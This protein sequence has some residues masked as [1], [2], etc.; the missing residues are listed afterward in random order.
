MKKNRLTNFN[1][2]R[3]VTFSIVGFLVLSLPQIPLASAGV[4]FDVQNSN[5]SNTAGNSK[6]PQLATVGTNV[7][8]VWED[9]TDIRF[10][11][12]ANNGASFATASAVDI[13]DNT[14]SANETP[15]PQIANSAG[16]DVYITWQDNE[17]IRFSASANNGASFA[18]ASAV[19]IGNTATETAAKPQIASSG[20]DVYIVWREGTDIRFSASANNGASFA[21]ASAVD[22]GDIN[23]GGTATARPSVQ[24]ASAGN[25]AYVIWVDAADI[26]FSASANNGAS[27]AVSAVDIGNTG[28]TSS[29]FTSNPQIAASGTNVFVIWEDGNTVKFRRSTDSGANFD[30]EISIGN[31]G[32]G[33]NSQPQ[34]AIGS[35]NNVFVVWQDGATGEIKYRQ[36]TDNGANFVAEQNLSN[37]STSS[38]LPQITASG[39]N[40]F[41]IWR[42]ATADTDDF[43][44]KFRSSTDSG[45]TFGS[46]V[47]LDSN[48]LFDDAP[49]VA[50]V[51]TRVYAV[52]EEKTGSAGTDGEIRFSAATATP[53]SVTFDAAQYRLSETA[54]V[55]IVDTDSNTDNASIQTISPTVTSTTDATGITLSLTETTASSGTFSGTMTFTTAVGGS[56][57]AGRILRVSTGDTITATFSSVSGTATIFPRTVEFHSTSYSLGD[58]AHVKVTDQNSNTDNAAIQ[59]IVVT[60]TSTTDTT[61]ISLTLT[62]T[63]ASSGIF[64]GVSPTFTNDLIFMRG[65]HLFP[66]P[67]SV[68]ITQIHTP[69]NT[70]PAA[71][72][73]T[74]VSVSST[75]DSTPPDVT[76][77]LT[78]NGANT[79]T[80]TGTLSLITG[81]S[82]GTSIQ[83]VA[84]D[85]L[86]ILDPTGTFATR[87][88][89]TP[90]TNPAK[91][92]LHVTVTDSSSDIVTATY[93]GSSASVPVI[94]SP[95]ESGGGGGGIVRP[96]L[97]LDVLAGLAGG[98]RDASPPS[99]TLT[100]KSI[101]DLKLDD[102]I[103][104]TLLEHDPFKPIPPLNDPTIE[105]P[106]SIS[107]NGYLL[108]AYA[109]T[110]VTNTIETGTPV[111]VNLAFREASSLEHV[112]LYTNLRGLEKEIPNSDTYIVYNK[113]KPVEVVDPHGIFSDVKVSIEKD[114]LKHRLK[115]DITF[116]KSMEK[117]D[118]ILRAW[119]QN[120][121]SID[122]KIFDA[123]Q[124]V[125][126]SETSTVSNEAEFAGTLTQEFRNESNNQNSV[127]LTPILEKWGGFSTESASDSE[128]LQEIGI[129]ASTIPSW[130]KENARWILKGD[131]SQQEFVDALRYLFE[132]GII[133]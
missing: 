100:T 80:F 35:G 3:L 116:A 18:T 125:E 69:A 39:T 112:A 4:V 110:I 10:S 119:D 121:N 131:V 117:S 111:E 48:A 16:S 15:N 127:N 81:P 27:F 107:D 31:A 79:A 124:V 65:T 67:G 33:V 75:T 28:G 133:N 17:D 129:E 132:K 68:T 72:D 105:Y 106:F 44:I 130:V 70:N 26:R 47:D 92:A 1:A 58:I 11:A 22:I 103:R 87:G 23:T 61:G 52:W 64:G 62:E 104:Q 122:T 42:E 32:L 30:S 20:N 38:T 86:T 57:S 36:S 76:I 120:K 54:T 108:P 41:V 46:A 5:L 53:I 98:G 115:Y 114:G 40:V 63:T 55:T 6:V 74:S 9:G 82:S 77:P 128:V 43:D 34:I 51:S 91:G 123:W 21:T 73:T 60:V 71:I 25:N 126:S 101:M 19:D 56:S 24:V 14:G 2:K 85:I 7:Y 59:T 99:F 96:S 78:E 83:A 50:A 118:I 94:L 8:V 109:N 95:G 88:L 102:S 90:C 12:S 93:L 97:V 13:G 89:V 45:A 29:S 49:Q 84:C 113:G 66:A 37:T